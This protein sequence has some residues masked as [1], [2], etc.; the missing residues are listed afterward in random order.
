MVMTLSLLYEANINLIHYSKTS[1][2]QAFRIWQYLREYAAVIIKSFKF[3]LSN[4][5]NFTRNFCQK[6]TAV[7]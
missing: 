1:W 3:V 7:Q 5:Q 2:K 6:S 4:F